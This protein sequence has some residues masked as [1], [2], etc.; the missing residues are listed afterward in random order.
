MEDGVPNL[1]NEAIRSLLDAAANRHGEPGIREM[2]FTVDDRGNQNP[3]SRVYS[4]C[5]DRRR[6]ELK[7]M[8]GPDWTFVHWRDANIECYKKT[9]DEVIKA[10]ESEP[11]TDFVLNT[12]LA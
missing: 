6:P 5:Y 9:R 7:R 2:P 11:K 12:D 8:C 3:E 10:G 4:M 1:R